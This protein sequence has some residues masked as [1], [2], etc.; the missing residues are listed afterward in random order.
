MFKNLKLYFFFFLITHNDAQ[1]SQQKFKKLLVVKST[2]LAPERP[3]IVK[4]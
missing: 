1:M 4:R 2:W 3:N